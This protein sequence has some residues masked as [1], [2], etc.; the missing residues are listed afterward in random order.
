MGGLSQFLHLKCIQTHGA[1]PSVAAKH[2]HLAGCSPN[3]ATNSALSPVGYFVLSVLPEI[4]VES[5]SP[6][7]YCAVYYLITFTVDSLFEVNGDG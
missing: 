6:Q 3:S 4:A 1:V 7:G 2:D 5:S